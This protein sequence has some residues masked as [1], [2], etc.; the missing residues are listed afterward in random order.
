MHIHFRGQKIAGG[1]Q[2][3]WE[4]RNLREYDNGFVIVMYNRY[5]KNIIFGSKLFLKKM[6][7][8]EIYPKYKA[9]NER[10]CI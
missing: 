5:C 7:T 10:T 3:L 8:D 4:A 9:T 2:G 1:I 6:D